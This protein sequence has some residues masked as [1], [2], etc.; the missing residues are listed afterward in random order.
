MRNAVFAAVVVLCACSPTAEEISRVAIP[1]TTLS[2]V[3]AQDEKG[4]YR[5]R[6]LEN[7]VSVTTDRIFGGSG[8][9]ASLQP[10]L[11]ETGGLVRISWSQGSL[12]VAFLEFDRETGQIARDSNLTD[13][14]PEIERREKSARFKAQQGFAGDARIAR[15]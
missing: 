15:A 5:Y 6:V 13:R 3:V 2:V 9:R 8:T 11:T 14:P 10:R 7:G 12:E 1:D 4:L